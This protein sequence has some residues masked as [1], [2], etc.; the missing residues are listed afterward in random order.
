MPDPALETAAPTELAGVEQFQRWTHLLGRGQQLM[1]EFMTREQSGGTPS[2]GLDPLGLSAIW[3]Q[4]A[5]ALATEPTKFIELQTRFMADSMALWQSFLTGAPAASPV[6]AVK[7][8]RFADPAWHDL[9]GFDFLKQSYLLTSQYIMQATGELDGLDDH[10]RAKALFHTRQFVDAMSPSN[11]PLTNPEVLK[12]TVDSGGENLI[13]G[14]EH[15]LGDLAE[16]RMKMTDETAFEVGRN[17][18]ATPGKVIF[19]NRLFQLIQYAPTT[20]TVA[21]I[22]LLV[23]PPWINKFYILDLTAEKSFIG[24][25]V[26]QGLTVFVVSWRS[27]DAALSDVTLDS[28][29]L[30]GQVQAIA[31]ALEATGAPAV[32]T[33]GYCVAGT[34]LAATLALLEAKGQADTVR[35]AT[36]FTAQV[37]FSDAGDLTVFVDDAQLDSIV[38]LTDGKGFLD[39]RYMATTF[40]MLRSNDLIWNYVINNYM[41]GKDYLPFDLLYWNSDATNVPACWHLSYLKDMYRDNLLVKPG[42]ITVAGVPIDLGTVHTPSYIQA[43]KEDHIAPA[44]SVYRMTQVFAGPMRFVLAGSG[45]IAG[46]VNPPAQHKY[47]FWTNFNL[48]PEFDSFVAGASETKGSWWPDWAAWLLP[49]SGKQVPARVPGDGPLKTIEDAPGRYVKARI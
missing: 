23:F 42:G 29:I 49:Q 46:V 11:F 39:G 9:P 33:I 26:A 5:T 19:E 4:A 37:D 21:E 20:P 1:L 40:N 10:A 6:A 2:L 13:N 16:G 8:K 30:E 17:V 47:Q 24:W 7:D 3:Q 36:F 44:R 48:P 38:K 34:T 28:Y 22:P 14:L 18:A 27:A 45:H 35:S 31:R 15:L 43:G 32:N 41:L 12:A 25:A